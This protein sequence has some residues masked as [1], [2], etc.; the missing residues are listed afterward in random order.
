MTTSKETLNTKVSLDKFRI[1]VFMGGRSIE[2]EVSFNS[3]RTVCDHIDTS[4]YEVVPLFQIKD[5]TIYVLPWKFLHRGKIT[6]FE[7][8]LD[9][10]ATR[11][12]WDDLK[13]IVDFVYISVHG[14]YA[15]DGTIQGFLE[16]LGIPYIGTKVFGSALGMNKTV[17]KDFLKLNKI[18]V[19]SG[20]T[21]KSDQIKTFNVNDF[22]RKI[23]IAGLSYPVIV[24]PEHEGSSLGVSVANDENELFKAIQFASRTDNNF[25][26]NVLVE[27]KIEGMEF[28][29][30][31]L[32]RQSG[33]NQKD[34]KDWFALPITEVVPEDKNSF[35]DYEQKYMPGRASKITPARC[36]PNILK[37]IQDV[38]LKATRI[39][40]FSTISRIDGFLTKDNKIILI[41]PNSLT[42]L[43][44]STFLWHQAAEIGMSHSQL[45]N[46]LIKT[47]LNNYGILQVKSNDTAENNSMKTGKKKKRVA[48]LLGGNTNEREISLE[49][50]RN[51]CYKL[52]PDKYEVIPLFVD[53]SMNLFK[54]DQKLLIQN[55]TREISKLVSK[56]L[57][58][59]W[60]GLSTICDFVFIG[61][62]GGFGEG[63]EVQGLL[64]ML[65]LPYNGSGVLASAL[66]MDKYKTSEFLRAKGF[67]VPRSFL[68]EK[69][70]WNNLKDKKDKEEYLIK[71]LSN[72]DFPVILKPHD[73]GCSV[74]VEKILNLKEVLQHTN[75][76]FEMFDKSIVMIEEFVI[77]VE[78]TCAV[79]G[80]DTVTV[81]P[82]SQVVA[83]EGVLSLEEKFLP[84][85]G[86]NITPA[87]VS[88][89]SLS[90]I[91]DTLKKVYQYIG[92]R[93]YVRIDFFLSKIL[94]SRSPSRDLVLS[95][96]NS[97]KE[98]IVILEINTLPGMT[99]ATCIF[100]Q[101]AE[102]QIR[103]MEFIDKIIELGFD[104]HK[105][106]D[107]TK[108]KI[109]F[110]RTKVQC[111]LSD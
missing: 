74:G 92:C 76:F 103:P 83:K 78:L 28:V 71:N 52:A 11:I 93:G 88:N 107:T 17:Q 68:I 36:T 8:R 41:D 23:K 42:G 109:N 80:N 108:D 55:S 44:P 48:V 59:K 100:H 18:D 30:V 24:K 84:G 98:K 39:L 7:N 1:G 53:N 43:G 65:G 35:Y 111:I 82:P 110:D 58:V 49:S 21:F 96:I 2:R 69:E 63:G 14:R 9:G 81:L 22:V 95:K 62:H 37:K 27:E 87:P 32:E 57:Q 85:E 86:E 25:Y 20:V 46:Y 38:C 50:G 90:L 91:Q 75:S 10:E 105:K 64:E 97:K 79:I 19:A 4:L 89:D 94:S 66:C 101:A 51:I 99:P 73:D 70:E 60:A 15:E 104:L 16:V 29:C 56:D 54:L 26:Q 61:L 13:N 33:P 45:I 3:G 47:E 40:N 67:N 31:C 34:K 106:I 12:I 72:F 5:G 77:G 102:I 6:D